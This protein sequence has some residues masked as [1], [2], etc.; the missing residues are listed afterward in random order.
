MPLFQYISGKIDSQGNGS[1]HGN[2]THCS[3]N[4]CKFI[5]VTA[6]DNCAHAFKEM[7]DYL[8]TEVKQG[9]AEMKWVIN[10]K[11]IQGFTEPTGHGV[12]PTLANKTTNKS[13]T[14]IYLANKKRLQG[15]CKFTF[16]CAK[17]LWIICLHV[18]FPQTSAFL[19]SQAGLKFY[20]Q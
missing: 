14:G 8:L 9:M 17:S 19:E 5:T 10:H 11:E 7:R 4:N 1:S 20:F 2:G 13:E 3:S 6:Q 15:I 18:H 12:A 16:V